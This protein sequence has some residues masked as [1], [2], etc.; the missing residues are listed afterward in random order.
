MVQT[1][2]T[3]GAAVSCHFSGGGPG[4]GDE[5][6]SHLA[7]TYLCRSHNGPRSNGSSRNPWNVLARDGE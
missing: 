7:S 4:G 6:D 1:S 2:E 5:S 3:R